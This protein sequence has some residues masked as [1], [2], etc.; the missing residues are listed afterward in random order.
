MS[1]DSTIQERSLS[2]FSMLMVCTGNIGRS[3]MMER[4]M[5]RELSSRGVDDVVSVSSAGTMGQVGQTM[6]PGA[7]RALSERGVEVADFSATLLTPQAVGSSDLILVATREH[8]SEVVNLLPGA[9]RRTF[10]LHELARVVHSAPAIPGSN[11]VDVEVHDL[12]RR[13]RD[14]VA[15]AGQVRGSVPRPHPED[16]DDL[17]DPLGAPDQVYRDRALAIAVSVERIVPYLLGG[18][19]AG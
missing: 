11:S 10:T 14:A 5:L 12:P 13:M 17:A 4:L 8:R 7:V 2:M 16:L 9:V 18:T 1:E 19:S 3:P 15:W 6:E